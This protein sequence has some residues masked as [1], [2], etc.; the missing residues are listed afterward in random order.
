M[1]SVAIDD[2]ALP[3][4][5][6]ATEKLDKELIAKYGEGQR[7]RVERGLRQVAEFWRAEE[8]HQQYLE[9]R[10]LAHCHL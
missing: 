6:D 2:Q 7:A 1:L 8:Y 4:M 3:W 10:G 9:K 5:K